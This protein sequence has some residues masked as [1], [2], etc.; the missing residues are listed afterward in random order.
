MNIL[1]LCMEILTVCSIIAKI[2]VDQ[3]CRQ[4]LLQTGTKG[5]A[6]VHMLMCKAMMG[7]TNFPLVYCWT[8]KTADLLPPH[9]SIPFELQLET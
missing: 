6:F 3:Q 1:V 4:E 5:W 8:F 2:R 7:R 9:A